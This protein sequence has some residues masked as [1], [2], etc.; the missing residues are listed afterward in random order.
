MTN[1]ET[2][3]KNVSNTKIKRAHLESQNTKSIEDSTHLS[4]VWTSE[5]HHHYVLFSIMPKK[6][7][8]YKVAF[9][10]CCFRPRPPKTLSMDLAWRSRA[11]KTYTRPR[12][13]VRGLKECCSRQSLLRRPMKGRG[14]ACAK[15]GAH[16]R[17]S[18][19]NRLQLKTRPSGIWVP[20]PMGASFS[21]DVAQCS[22]IAKSF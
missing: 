14:R 18:S 22:R 17:S 11:W 15:M 4:C 8:S 13:F 16:S 6:W 20:S 9:L 7:L 19:R 2:V 21:A 1:L 3:N 10:L 12:G 5:G